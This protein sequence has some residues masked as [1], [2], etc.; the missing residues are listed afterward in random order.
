MKDALQQS[1]VLNTKKGDEVDFFVTDNQTKTTRLVQ[2]SY[3]MS[4]EKTKAREFS[5]MIDTR[6]ETGVEDCTIVTWDE[7]GEED[8]ISIVPAWKWLLK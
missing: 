7:E 1:R 8:G 5:A 3:E 2:V 4:S 6:R